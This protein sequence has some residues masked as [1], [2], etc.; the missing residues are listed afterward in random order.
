MS[1]VYSNK[2]DALNTALGLANFEDSDEEENEIQIEEAKGKRRGLLY[3]DPEGGYD[4]SVGMESVVLDE[5]LDEMIE[6]TE[7][8]G[9]WMNP[10]LS[11]L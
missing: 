7:C 8:S 9:V 11:W 4:W 1:G 5:H 2:D 10:R 6:L 3:T